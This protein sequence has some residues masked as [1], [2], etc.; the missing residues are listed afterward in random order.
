MVVYALC[1]SKCILSSDPPVPPRETALHGVLANFQRMKAKNHSPIGF[2]F[3][4][5][6]L[7]PA[8]GPGLL[9][10]GSGGVLGVAWHETPETPLLRGRKRAQRG[11]E[12]EGQCT[13]TFLSPAGG[14][15]T[16]AAKV[17]PGAN[18]SWPRRARER[19]SSP[20]GGPCPPRSP[21]PMARHWAPLTGSGPAAHPELPFW[22]RLSG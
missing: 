4:V 3:Q 16:T 14:S 7:T 17:S 20:V 15:E 21:E 12:R 10:Q 13:Q 6:D 1:L 22:H 8:A 19:L 11:R 9:L 5:S 2:G 18:V